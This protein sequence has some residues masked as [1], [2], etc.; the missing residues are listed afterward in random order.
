MEMEYVRNLHS[1]YLRI[2]LEEKPEEKRYQYCILSRGGIR[3]LLNCELRYLDEKA[4][5]YYDI[6]SRQNIAQLYTGQTIKRKW[7]QDFLQSLRQLQHELDRFLL[8]EQGCQWNPENIFQDLE[9]NTFYFTYVP[10]YHGESEFDSLLEFMMRQLDYDDDTLVECVYK[11]AEQYGQ[12]GMVYLQEQIFRDARVLEEDVQVRSMALNEKQKRTSKAITEECMI[13]PD[14]SSE[15]QP[16]REGREG[17]VTN[18]VRRD[19]YG[20]RSL[21]ESR[22]KKDRNERER[23]QENLQQLMS[24]MAV[25]EQPTYGE[26]EEAEQ[27][28]YGATIYI[29]ENTN[30]NPTRRLYTMDGKLDMVL[31]KQDIIIGKKQGTADVVLEDRSISRLHAKIIY[32][33][34]YY[35]EDM[36]STNGTF[37]NG[38][39]LLPYEKRELESGDEIRCG[40]CMLIFR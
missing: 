40:Q 28:D 19:K 22:R 23:Y 25:A 27:Q 14:S 39:R 16:V 18:H 9:K 8:D 33:G 32:D 11:M 29:E 5:L 38:L 4:Y 24:G 35:L 34:A 7:V 21:F 6:T 31:P 10:Y 3:G 20:I 30:T 12:W 2:Q 15:Q 26:W 1:N 13:V 37:K 36:N 17:L